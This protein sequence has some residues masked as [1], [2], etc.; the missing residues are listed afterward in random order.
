MVRFCSNRATLPASAY[1]FSL[2]EFILELSKNLFNLDM[3]QACSKGFS[4]AYAYPPHRTETYLQFDQHQ[5]AALLAVQVA[6]AAKD[7][8][9]EQLMRLVVQSA[10]DVLPQADG[11]V[12]EMREGDTLCYRAASGSIANHVGTRISITGSLAGQCLQENTTLYCRDTLTDARVDRDVCARLGIRSMLVLPIRHRGEVIGVFKMCASEAHAFTE[13]DQLVAQFFVNAIAAGFGSAA[14][15]AA[16]QALKDSEARFDRAVRGSSEGIWDWDLINRHIYYSPRFKALLGYEDHE[17]GDTIEEWATL[18]HPDDYAGVMQKVESHL[19]KEAPYI[20]EYRLRQ[21]SGEYA[22]FEARGQAEWN[23]SGMAVR[24]SGCLRDIADQKRLEGIKQEFV[25]T[26]TH[27]LR[28]PLTALKGAL[29]LM[30]VLYKDQIPQAAHNMLDLAMLGSVRLMDLINDL[31]DIGKMEAG[32]MAYTMEPVELSG[33]LQETIQINAPYGEK[34][35]VTYMLNHAAEAMHVRI[36]KGRFHQV[37]ANLLSNAAKF[38]HSGDVVEVHTRRE[39]DHCIVS[40]R[41]H[42]RGIA[43]EFQPRIF[44]KFAQG[45]SGQGTGL[46]LSIAKTITEDMQGS[47]WFESTP[48]QGTTFHMKLPMDQLPISQS[49][50][51]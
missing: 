7:T 11:S 16:V 40:V 3:L 44:Q 41:D 17:I 2:C 5:Q 37:M 20:A 45:Q 39:A 15:T 27:E 19:A 32:Q 43:H 10:R 21:K 36:D 33:I 49:A 6:V 23:A 29:D 18:L 1:I 25:Y 47:L 4:M 34:H 30:N 42:G 8:N 35:A 22:W 9:L 50:H 51:A 48:G 14:E 46:G 13:S 12:I 26:V 38:S 24:M 31:L 28:T